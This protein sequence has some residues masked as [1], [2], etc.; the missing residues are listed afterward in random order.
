MLT[1][2]PAQQYS[3]NAIEFMGF[4]QYRVGA[5]RNASSKSLVATASLHWS[6]TGCEQKI[7]L[8]FIRATR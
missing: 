7:V 8:C 6:A 4:V 5:P 3:F 2:N 1:I